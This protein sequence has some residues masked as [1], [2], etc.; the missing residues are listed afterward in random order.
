MADQRVNGNLV[1]IGNNGGTFAFGCQPSGGGFT[2][3]LPTTIPQIGQSLVISSVFNGNTANLQ[4]VN[5]PTAVTSVSIAASSPIFTIAGSPVTTSGTISLG[6][7][8]QS[9]NT[10]FAGPA[11][12]T[13]VPTF[14]TLG[15]S[16]IPAI[17]ALNGSLNLSQL[18]QGGATSSQVLTWNGTAWA[19]AAPS[20]SVFSVFG[21]TGV[22]VA[23]SGDYS[24]A[25]IS[26]T[27]QLA[28]S[29]TA[30]SGQFF[31]SF[32][33]STGLFTSATPSA[34]VASVFGRTGVV[35]ATSGDYTVSQVTGAA[36]L[37]SPSFTGTATMSNAHITGTLADELNSVGTSNQ[38][39][40]STVTGTR[41]QTLGGG[42][43][44]SSFSSGNF[45]PLFTTSVATPSTTPALSFTAVRQSPNLVFAGPPSGV[46][47]SN[48]TF[49][50]LVDADLPGGTTGTGAVVLASGPSFSGTAAFVNISLTGTFAD[51][52]GHVGTSGQVL[53]STGSGTLWQTPTVTFDNVGS[54]TNT[55]ATMTV[56]TGASLTFSG[57]GTINANE[58][59]S[60][61]VSNT[62]PSAGQVLTATSP[63]AAQ[64]STPSSSGAVNNGTA[65]QLAWYVTTG[66]AVSGNANATI[67]SGTLTLGQVGSVA[68]EVL[69]SGT[70]AGSSVTV[71]VDTSVFTP[72]TLTLPTDPGTAAYVLETDGA[73][74]T[75]WVPQTGGG[76]G[77]VTSFSSGNLS[78]LFTTSVSN[79]TTT[80]ALSFTAVNE[81]AH[82]VYAGPA[83]GGSAA[84]TFRQLST[85]DLSD[86]VTGTGAIVLANAPTFTAN[87]T[88]ASST[89][90]GAVVLA[91]GPSLTG[92]TT[93]A[94]EHITGTLADGGGSVGTSGQVLS[95]TGT[96]TLWITSGGGGGS[97]SGTIAANQIAFGTGTNAIGGDSVFTWDDSTQTFSAAT[98][99]GFTVTDSSTSTGIALTCTAST[100]GGIQ[101]TS[102]G[103]LALTC[104]VEMDLLD[105]GN[106][107]FMTANSNTESP[108]M[109]LTCGQAGG[110]PSSNAFFDIIV[111]G[112]GGGS[113]TFENDTTGNVGGGLFFFDKSN[114]GFFFNSHSIGAGVGGGF[115]FNGQS[116]A[117]FVSFQNHGSGGTAFT[118][119]GVGGIFI[120]AGVGGQTG[121]F[122][123]LESDGG[124]TGSGVQIKDTG[125]FA[126]IQL[127]ANNVAPT[128]HGNAVLFSCADPNGLYMN[129]VAGASVTLSGGIA[130]LTT[131]NGIVTAA[132]A[133]SDERLKTNIQPF[134]RGLESV[135]A[136]NPS[137][138]QWN[139]EGQAYTQLPAD[140]VQHGFIAQDVQKALPEAIGHEGDYLSIDNRT[141]MAALVNAVKELAAENKS[142]QER[143]KKLENN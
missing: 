83:S 18:S 21:R 45:N 29:F 133:T 58:I 123:L 64:W 9:A 103:E 106:G 81:A 25:Q 1:L 12:G 94:N 44:V 90:S 30:P 124:G 6:L 119:A 120:Q 87:P 49:R 86:G 43:S 31:T 61:V 48:P 85:A 141:L 37:A 56:G 47:T 96:G 138:F 54:G 7:A 107:I 10:V 121:A 34:Q 125:G 3:L 14:R 111:Q 11:T 92:T 91:V 13:A 73:G 137:T 66:T 68:G 53:T 122:L 109:I 101:L 24:Y 79:P 27:P 39:L 59:Y 129:N 5:P 95:S 26:G 32:T 110:S 100:G 143:I 20:G 102:A 71:T 19:P 65:G 132:T 80:P 126:G 82:L 114:G 22:V 93:V 2:Y 67:S 40:T 99:G 72:W 55:T 15:A 135:V 75:S 98:A 131:H 16:D 115:S 60:V 50:A 127:I 57:T 139:E 77:S 76:G 128:E 8:T 23:Q 17:S 41:W 104:A 63:T 112:T 118:D 36:P 108:N 62:A 84:P 28:Q 33:A 140:L 35:V 52:V 117:D 38:V 113:M 69:F 97:I 74:K 42:G 89:G 70:G 78:P 136:I 51:N 46:L 88:F 105:T 142:L 4:W 134:T 130:T 116:S